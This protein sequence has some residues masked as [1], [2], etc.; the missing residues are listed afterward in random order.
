MGVGGR[1]GG[2]QEENWNWNFLFLGSD[3]PRRWWWW[4]LPPKPTA[5]FLVR[6]GKRGWWCL[7]RKSEA[8]TSFIAARWHRW[9]MYILFVPSVIAGIAVSEYLN[10]ER[11]KGR[12]RGEKNYSISV[13]L[14]VVQS[15]NQK[16]RVCRQCVTCYLQVQAK[17]SFGAWR[18]K[19]LSGKESDVN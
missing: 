2:G 4:K 5:W 19:Q 7:I 16:W 3:T 6:G 1:G 11:K 10:C 15:N 12:G 14:C 9:L 13:R 17:H 8:N 18:V